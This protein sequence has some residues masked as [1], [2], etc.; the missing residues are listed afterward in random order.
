MGEDAGCPISPAPF[1]E[2]GKGEN[3]GR[4]PTVPY[5]SIGQPVGREDVVAVRRSIFLRRVLG[6]IRPIAIKTA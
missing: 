1:P 6:Y 3:V 2:R 5:S 4:Y